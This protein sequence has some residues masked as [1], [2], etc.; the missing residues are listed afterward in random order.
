MRITVD[1][2]RCAGSGLCVLTDMTLFDQDQT[3]GR[4]F[5]SVERP[6]PEHAEAAREAAHICPSRAI[7]VEEG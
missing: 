7:T 5:V 3:D 6:G 2:D 1:H 4:A